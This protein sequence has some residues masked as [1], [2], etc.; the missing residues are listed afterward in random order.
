M[1]TIVGWQNWRPDY[2]VIGH[3][4]ET[5]LKGVGGTLSACAFTWF[6]LRYSLV[7]HRRFVEKLMTQGQLVRIHSISHSAWGTD[8]VGPLLGG[9][10]R[11]GWSALIRHAGRRLP[12]VWV[13]FEFELDGKTRRGG[14][15]FFADEVPLV[16]DEGQSWALVKGSFEH[17]VLRM[18]GEF[19]H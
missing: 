1:V 10:S 11:F 7:F 14:E 3:V 9:A 8:I 6:G 16:D 2:S 13:T 5:V 12:V 19:E 15:R 18:Q 17:C 4:V